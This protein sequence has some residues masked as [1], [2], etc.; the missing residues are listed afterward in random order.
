[1]AAPAAAV[2]VVDDEA[3]MRDT[4]TDILV[5][6]G[7]E[8][9]SAGDGEGALAVLRSGHFDAVVMD[10]RMPGMDG[11]SVLVEIGPPPPPVIM[12]TAYALEEQLRRAVAS[13]AFA[14]VHKPFGVPHLLSLV[15]KAVHQGEVGPR[16]GP[17]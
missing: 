15:D 6:A 16:P 17:P 10:I 9:S 7:Y 5:D 8:V 2:L 3:G 11:V 14:V 12:M 4:L 13:H 1:M